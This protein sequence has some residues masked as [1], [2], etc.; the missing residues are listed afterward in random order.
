M[1][2]NSTTPKTGDARPAFS[3]NSGQLSE[4]KDP[5]AVDNLD[6]EIRWSASEFVAHQKNISWYLLLAVATMT[7]SGLVFLLTSQYISV[8]VI[9]V[10]GVAFGVYGSV[11]PK[12]L[13]YSIDSTGIS[14]EKKHYPYDSFRVIQIIQGGSVPSVTFVP[15][16]R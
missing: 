2:N 4:I 1:E 11:P 7:L 16:K 9:I 5:R 12:S 6:D 15:L 3:Y 13:E 8:G 10:L 14:V